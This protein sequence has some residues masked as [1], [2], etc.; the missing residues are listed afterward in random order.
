MVER[1]YYMEKIL[2]EDEKIETA[3]DVYDII[4]GVLYF[5]NNNGEEIDTVPMNAKVLSVRR[6]ENIEYVDE[7]GV[8]FDEY[9]IVLDI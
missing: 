6:L 4:G 3:E 2:S 5:V 9:E 7:N 1:E 8:R